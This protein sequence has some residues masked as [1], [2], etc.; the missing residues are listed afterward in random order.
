MLIRILYKI[1]LE[2]VFTIDVVEALERGLKII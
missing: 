1:Y 2:H